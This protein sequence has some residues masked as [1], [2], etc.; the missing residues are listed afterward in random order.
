MPEPG[1]AP[2]PPY[3]VES[4]E[5]GT[6]ISIQPGEEIEGC[7]PDHIAPA[8]AY[9]ST[10]IVGL[11]GSAGCIP[12][13][14][15]FFRGIEPDTGSAYVVVVHLSPEHESTL[16]DILQR[17]ANIPVIQ[18]NES[19]RVEP[20]TVYVIP[21]AKTLSMKDGHISVTDLERQAGRRITV[22][23][24]FRT[25]A[26]THGP[27]SCAIILSGSDSDGCIG[28]KRIKERGGLTVAQDPVEAPYDGMPRGA[29]ATGM[30]DWVLP[31]QEMPGKLAAYREN[32]RR[33]TAPILAD[34]PEEKNNA[35][36][37]SD[38]EEALQRVLSFL[39]VN[40]GRDFSYYKRPTVLRRILRRMQVTGMTD[41][42]AYFAYLRRYPRNRT[43]SCR[44]F[45]S[46]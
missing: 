8:G 15:D 2:E 42:A 19:T 34:A 31:V 17:A 29:I 22:D 23:I 32:G 1:P 10:S 26:D 9:Q 44:T 40:T 16:A 3:P 13:L 43:R 41:F 39:R 36:P 25:L 4:E 38:G 5:R 7:E 24:F 27:Q 20:N 33:I 46:A 14:L 12:F 21:P 11:G 18:V 6:S 30:I 35:E 37:P 28:I 45:L